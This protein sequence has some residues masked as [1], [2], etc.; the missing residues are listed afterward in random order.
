MKTRVDLAMEK[1]KK[2]YNCAQAI[3][4]TYC[5]LVGLDEETA[6]RLTEGLGA[7]MGNLE[8][9][10]GA[11]AAACVL[12]GMKR[13]SGNLEKPDSKGK[14]YQLSREMMNQFEEKAG[15][16]ICKEIKGV[17]TGKILHSCANC[18]LDAAKIA[19]DVLFFEEDV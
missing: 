5:D 18:V 17:E 12:A 9:S 19:E 6:F 7:G 13:S 10:C 4:C 2:G 16:V 15:S 11:I 1:H 8:G 3:A 14:T